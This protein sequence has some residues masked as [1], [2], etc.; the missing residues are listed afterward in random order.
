ME[1]NQIFEI[2][3]YKEAVEFANKYG[4]TIKEIKDSNPR[5]FQIVEVIISEKEL[6]LYRIEEL[7]Q[8]LFN[9]DYQA[10]KYAEGELSEE[11]YA[12]MRIQRKLWRD[13][14]NQLEEEVQ[15]A[16]KTE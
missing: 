8:K 12:P 6:K 11:E 10:I 4:Y 7:K 3:Q 16:A 9:T 13:E 1:L 2:E 15:N 5:K 14:I